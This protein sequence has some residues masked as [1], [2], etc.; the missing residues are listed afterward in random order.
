M[1]P[2]LF[3]KNFLI[4]LFLLAALIVLHYSGL[5]TPVEN[6]VSRALN[7]V[8]SK[9]YSWG[10]NIKGFF[11]PSFEERELQQDIEDLKARVNELNAENAELVAVK[12]E[13]ERLREYLEFTK[14]EELE[15]KMARVVSRGV[16]MKADRRNESILINKGESDGLEKGMVAVNSQGIVVGKISGVRSSVSEVELITDEEC[17]LAISIQNQ[18]GTMGIA[19]GEMGL[20]VHIDY[21]P[22]T[23]DI[24][25]GDRVV[26]SGL[27][28]NVPAGLIIGEVKKVESKSNDVWQTAVVEP[29]IDLE[30][31]TMVAVVL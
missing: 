30:E 13:N 24:S 21:I 18:E 15:Q 22:Q 20:T 25:K 31:L 1:L 5:L 14:E 27:E 11:Y 7:P 8:T 23:Q 4:P 29:L 26:T 9:V 17:E 12:K 16:F 10:V 19:R 28:E 2:K 3:K 6:T